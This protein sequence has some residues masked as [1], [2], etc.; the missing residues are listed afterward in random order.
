MFASYLV[1]AVKPWN[2]EAFHRRTPVIT[3][4]WRLFDHPEQLTMNA[5]RQLSP[6]YIF[7]PHWSWR[8]P[9][10]LLEQYECVCF[11]MTDVPYGR[12]G[13]PLQN[14]IL[15]G[16]KSTMLSAL[17]MVD[18]LD[19]GP[20]YLKAPLSL[21]GAAE[22]IYARAADLTYDLITKIIDTNLVPTAQVGNPTIFHRRTPEQ[23][24]LPENATIPQI[25]DLIRMV[26]APTYPKAF[27]EY[28]N[29]RFEFSQARILSDD[30][31]EATVVIRKTRS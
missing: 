6:R 12:G 30:H 24:Y 16:H 18:E 13:S 5:L 28:G 2:V 10:E 15:R 8:V 26:D 4:S 21:E 9:S 25:Y 19:G 14:L 29:L 23:S 3:G 22:D 31:I 1:C 17:R 7:F 11:H 20:V 27:V